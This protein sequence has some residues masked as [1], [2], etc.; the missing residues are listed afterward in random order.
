MKSTS[1][2]SA[3]L[4]LLAT[5][6]ILATACSRTLSTETGKGVCTV[7]SGLTYS[8]SKDTP[9]TVLGIRQNNAKRASFCKK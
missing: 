6:C 3:T 8:A 4:L 9:E 1:K 2:T 7:W 5:L